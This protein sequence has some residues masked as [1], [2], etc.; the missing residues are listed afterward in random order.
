MNLGSYMRGLGIGMLVTALIMGISN[1]GTAAALT[2][3]E[4]RERAKKIGMIE[5]AVLA[6]IERN[7]ND[8]AEPI[9]TPQPSPSASLS[10]T[11]APTPL[12]KEVVVATGDDVEDGQEIDD[13]EADDIE[14]NNLEANNIEDTHEVIVSEPDIINDS[15]P[16]GEE[17]AIQINSGDDSFRVSTRLENAGL[18]STASD[19]NKYLIDGGHSRKLRTGSH[20]IPIDADYQ[21]IARILTGG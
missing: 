9:E 21:T 7:N 20:S 11:P 16:T 1:S 14:A 3:D 6:P 4:I 18:V 17:V 19:F 15:N 5:N 10:A 12:P 2:D 13:N 8:A